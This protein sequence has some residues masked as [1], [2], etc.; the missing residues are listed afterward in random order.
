VGVLEVTPLGLRQHNP[1]N[2]RPSTQPWQGQIG[3]ENGFCVFDTYANGIRA[4]CKQLIAYQDRYGLRTVREA[5][6][7]WA[8]PVDHNDTS[9]YIAMVCTVLDC[10][11]DD[12]FDFHNPDFLFW[13]ATAIGEQESGHDAFTHTVTDADIDAGIAAALA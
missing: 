11:P 9:A 10:S 8:P 2:I 12:P 13:M 1:G 5:I 6:S 7:R 4:L 3:V